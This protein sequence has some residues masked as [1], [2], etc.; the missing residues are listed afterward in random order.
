MGPVLQSPHPDPLHLAD[1][2]VIAGTALVSLREQEVNNEG[3]GPVLDCG[4]LTIRPRE[5]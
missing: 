5:L 1:V 3:G 2:A 4:S